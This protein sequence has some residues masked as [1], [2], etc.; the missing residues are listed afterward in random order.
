M[1]EILFVPHPHF[2]PVWRRCFDRPAKGY[3]MTVR[4]YADV[5]ELCINAW[6]KIAKD[7][8][9]FNDGQTAPEGSRARHVGPGA[10]R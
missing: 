4:S 1:K 5:E 3:G 7:G 9:P 10:R 2:D 6:L 8:Y